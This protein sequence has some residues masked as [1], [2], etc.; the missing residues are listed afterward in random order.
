[1]NTNYPTI[2]SSI[3]PS[4]PFN[5]EQQEFGIIDQFLYGKQ[6]MGLTTQISQYAG[7][8]ITVDLAVAIKRPK[9]PN[10]PVGGLARA[11]PRTGRG[12]IAIGCFCGSCGAPSS[13]FALLRYL[14]VRH[15]HMWVSDNGVFCWCLA[16]L[17]AGC[18]TIYG[19]FHGVLG[20][21]WAKTGVQSCINCY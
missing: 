18:T 12:S 5:L 2:N 4:I 9:M 15:H 17:D 10:L 1:M 19:G 13:C 7:S 3:C 6:C 14:C 11:L 21:F 8:T 20:V 16:A